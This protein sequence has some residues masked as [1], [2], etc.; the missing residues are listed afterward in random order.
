MFCSIII[1]TIGRPSL[2]KTLKSAVDQT[3]SSN[4]FEIIVVNDSGTPLKN[5]NWDTQVQSQI[6]NTNKHERSIARNTGAAV[7]RGKYLLFLDDDDSLYPNA[8]QNFQQLIDTTE[9]AWLYGSTQVVNRSGQPLLKLHHQ[10]NGNCFV[11]VLAGEWI[12]LQASL[13]RAD[14][15]FAVGGFN[16]LLV[17]PEDIDLLRRI[18]LNYEVAGTEA[19]VSC[20]AMGEEGSTTDYDHH[21][22]RSRWARE[23]ILDTAGVFERMR[24]SATSGYWHGR[25]PRAY[26]TSMIW[27]IQRKRFSTAASRASFG[28]YALFLAGAAAFSPTFWQALLKPYSSQTFARGLE[29]AKK[30][31]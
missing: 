23:K 12:P 24:K 31:T 26:L 5:T 8:L 27:N 21:P 15:F 30:T 16:P 10:L 20:V 14:A 28:L 25:I 17:G 2:E 4:N 11:Q 19:L 3:I 13:I 18:A 6:I 22:E 7:A 1:P 29:K 9:A